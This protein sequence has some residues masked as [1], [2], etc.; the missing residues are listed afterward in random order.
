MY[1]VYKKQTSYDRFH[2]EEPQRSC[3]LTST[4]YSPWQIH[5]QQTI[6]NWK[7]W[8]GLLTF[9][10]CCVPAQK[11][12]EGNQSFSDITQVGNLYGLKMGV[13]DSV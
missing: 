1:Y 13:R 7:H 11:K 2:F 12:N 10:T 9:D 8:K 4:A 6:Y 3:I 5:N